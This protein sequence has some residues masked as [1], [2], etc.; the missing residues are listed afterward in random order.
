VSVFANL[1]PAPVS[2]WSRQLQGT[3]LGEMVLA[4]VLLVGAGLFDG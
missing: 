4:L 2:D 1:A 3:G